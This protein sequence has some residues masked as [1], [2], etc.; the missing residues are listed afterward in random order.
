MEKL[1][2][3]GQNN[4]II[5]QLH[6]DYVAGAAGAAGTAFSVLSRVDKDVPER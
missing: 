6:W 5:F 4:L 1:S 3:L 2:H